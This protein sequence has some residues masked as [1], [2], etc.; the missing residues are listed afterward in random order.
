M[1]RFSIVF[2][3][4]FTEFLMT[5]SDM[6]ASLWMGRRALLILPFF[7]IFS[8]L[9]SLLYCVFHTVRMSGQLFFA[10]AK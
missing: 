4:E 7:E 10:T 6:D 1:K 5:I 9:R 2:N 3:F 8:K